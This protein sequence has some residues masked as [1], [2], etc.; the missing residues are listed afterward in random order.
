MPY[1]K[2]QKGSCKKKIFNQLL[3]QKFHGVKGEQYVSVS[4]E[5]IFLDLF[6][7]NVK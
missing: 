7:K 2:I 3:L 1:G 6:A 4:N 5:N